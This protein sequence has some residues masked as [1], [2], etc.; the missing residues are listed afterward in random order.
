MSNVPAKQNSTTT[1]GDFRLFCLVLK[2]QRC[3]IQD[4]RWYTKTFFFLNSITSKRYC[5]HVEA[6]AKKIQNWK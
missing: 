2:E 3:E 1:E 5:K 4:S 6:S